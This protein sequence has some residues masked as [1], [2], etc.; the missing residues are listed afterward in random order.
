MKS[1]TI[2]IH[3]LLWATLFL[4]TMA[5]VHTGDTQSF[6][7]NMTQ[8]IQSSGLDF[9]GM[10]AICSE[11]NY[12]PQYSESCPVQGLDQNNSLSCPDKNINDLNF[13]GCV[14]SN[15][16]V[17]ETEFSYSVAM[18]QNLGLMNPKDTTLAVIQ[19]FAFIC[20]NYVLK[21]NA[22]DIYS[23]ITSTINPVTIITQTPVVTQPASTSE[24]APGATG[25]LGFTMIS[26]ITDIII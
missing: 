9:C 8:Y 19:Q 3:L 17:W 16:D 24:I 12:A 18:C 10:C 6:L 7:S 26:Q 22:I 21:D 5:Q 2:M 11:C 1:S 13:W 25:L 23:I 15:S 4:E 20:N 14:C